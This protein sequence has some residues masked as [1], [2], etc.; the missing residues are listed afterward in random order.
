MYLDVYLLEFA[1]SEYIQAFIQ[2]KWLILNLF[3]FQ[4]NSHQ[5]C[6]IP[7]LNLQNDIALSEHGPDVVLQHRGRELRVGSAQPRHQV[8]GSG[9]VRSVGGCGGV[10]W[11]GNMLGQEVVEG[12]GRMGWRGLWWRWWMARILSFVSVVFDDITIVIQIIYIGP[13]VMGLSHCLVWR[14]HFQYLALDQCHC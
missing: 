3:W 9:K 6:I 8:P 4:R 13:C 11:G 10:N 5:S 2:Q 1:W 14:I 7:A 12:G